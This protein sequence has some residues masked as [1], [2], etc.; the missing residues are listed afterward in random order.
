LE[1]EFERNTSVENA[2]KEKE[3]PFH[4]GRVYYQFENY[5]HEN[6]EIRMIF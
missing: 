2:S 5:Q 1:K 3:K 6:L 4:F